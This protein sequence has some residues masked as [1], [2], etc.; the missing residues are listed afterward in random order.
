[1][2]NPYLPNPYQPTPQPMPF[3]PI[4]TPAYE[5]TEVKRVN[6]S[7][8]VDAYQ[9]APRSSILL[10]DMTAPLVWLV[11]TDDAGFK[12]KTPY[13]IEPYV[14]ESVPDQKSIDDRFSS[15]DQRLT[16][17]EEALK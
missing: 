14:Q 13:K 3:A 10:L 16:A 4:S 9:M 5:Q 1:M 8:G 11:Q 6:G 2:Y 15:I 12:T 17:L 7:Q